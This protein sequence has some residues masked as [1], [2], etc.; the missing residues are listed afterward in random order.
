[1]Q[2]TERVMN[3]TKTQGKGRKAAATEEI[4]LYEINKTIKKK[5]KNA[6][7]NYPDATKSDTLTVTTNSNYPLYILSWML[8]LHTQDNTSQAGPHQHIKHF[9]SLDELKDYVSKMEKGDDDY[10]PHD[11]ELCIRKPNSCRGITVAK[12]NF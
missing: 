10:V 2:I 8:A 7:L 9:N 12:L 3:N 5:F 6:T 11:L 4:S 1:M